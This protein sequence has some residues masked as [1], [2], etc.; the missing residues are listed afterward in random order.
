MK[1]FA[2]FRGIREASRRHLLRIF[3]AAWMRSLTLFLSAGT[4]LLSACGSGSSSSNSLIPPTF[5]GNWQFTMA[6]PSDGSFLGGLQGGFLLQGNGS[7]TGAATYSVSLPNFLIPCN[8]GSA[9]ITGTISGQSIN[10][11]T[12]VAGTQTFTLTGTLSL[13]GTAMAGTYQST[14]GTAGDGSP[15]GTSQT[16]LQW[17]AILVPPLT[18]SLQGNFHSAGGAAGLNEQDFLVSAEFTQAANTGANYAT[19]TGNLSF[20]NSITNESGYPCFSVASVYGQISG[21]SVTLEMFG[22]NGSEWG[23]IGEPVN[24]LGTTGINLVTL[25]A[26]NGGYVLQGT[27]PSYL[28]A[29]T[30]CPGTFA[31]ISSSGDFGN[32]C[33]A[34]NGT[35]ACQQ[36]ITF[37]PSALIFPVQTLG[38][39]PTTQ[40]IT[41][42][43]AT[44]APV[45]DVTLSLT[46]NDGVSNFAETDTCGVNGVPSQGQPFNLISGQPCVVTIS[47]APLETCAVGTPAAQCPSSL[48]ATLTATS[49]NNEMIITVPITGT[50]ANP[51][52]V[53]IPEIDGG[54]TPQTLLSSSNRTLQDA[55]HHAEIN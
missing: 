42:A 51:I 26:V 43:T 34:L 46:N 47:F 3:F 6:A 27:G 1:T 31:N 10:A 23:L 29:T 14:A 53:S 55:E 5:S 32:M 36:P 40:T 25:S 9:A 8:T 18:G 16:G 17:S 15:C 44:S 54:Q 52:A 50:G 24:S 28:V 4:L 30:Q 21:N 35:S 12:A 7:V 2:K 19:V 11:L 13:D 38:T 37:T 49:P 20:V 45:G 39:I 33:L 41:L 22:P 48:N